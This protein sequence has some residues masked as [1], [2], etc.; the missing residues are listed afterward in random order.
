M[1]STARTI[2]N[3][4]IRS[5]PRTARSLPAANPMASLAASRL[6][7][8]RSISLGI[9][10]R[11]CSRNNLVS[12]IAAQPACRVEVDLPPD[13]PRQLVLHAEELPARR[14][15]GLEFDEHV[16]VAVGPEI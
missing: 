6:W 5:E 4:N 13:D 7:R 12:K 2:A 8:S 9:I 1:I 10:D 15:T 16:H 3:W 11:Q 14:V